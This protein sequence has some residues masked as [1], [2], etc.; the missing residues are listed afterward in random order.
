MFMVTISSIAF[1]VTV[2][3]RRQTP[4]VAGEE[5]RFEVS[6]IGLQIVVVIERFEV[7]VV[8]EQLNDPATV[9]ETCREI[10]EYVGIPHAGLRQL[11]L[12]YERQ[13]HLGKAVD[14]RFEEVGYHAKVAR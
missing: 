13:L 1:F 12:L 5:Q 6:G 4:P 2:D 9:T 8:V 14:L 10:V 7:P 3:S 11:N